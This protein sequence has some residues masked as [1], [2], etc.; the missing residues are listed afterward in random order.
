[1]NTAINEAAIAGGADGATGANTNNAKEAFEELYSCPKCDKVNRYYRKEYDWVQLAVLPL[2]AVWKIQD[3][4]L[5][6][7]GNKLCEKAS[8]LMCIINVR[9]PIVDEIT[10]L[11][12]MCR[13]RGAVGRDKCRKI[14][15]PSMDLVSMTECD[16]ASIGGPECNRHA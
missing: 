4:E 1:M 9:Y 8:S 2:T 12:G 7:F 15:A 5:N 10:T 11:L 16:I 14:G 3:G 6:D 13:Q